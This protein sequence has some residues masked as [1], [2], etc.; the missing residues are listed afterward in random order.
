MDDLSVL[1]KGRG[2]Q[3][4]LSSITQENRDRL[5]ALQPLRAR[6]PDSWHDDDWEHA[7]ILNRLD[8]IA[9]RCNELLAILQQMAGLD[10]DGG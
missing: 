2:Q 1:L 10:L 9:V 8:D 5:A 7:D 4:H 6:N 3:W